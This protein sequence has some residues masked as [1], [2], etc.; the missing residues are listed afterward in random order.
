M[1]GLA[2]APSMATGK[3]MTK[4][5]HRMANTKTGKAAS[6]HIVQVSAKYRS[7]AIRSVLGCHGELVALIETSVAQ[8]ARGFGGLSGKSKRVDAAVETDEVTSSSR[9]GPE[10]PCC[11]VGWRVSWRVSWRASPPDEE[12]RA[13][14][15]PPPRRPCSAIS[16]QPRRTCSLRP[17]CCHCGD[18][19]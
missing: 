12:R 15:Q 6:N 2:S 13:E 18:R 19:V 5:F 3:M 8:P 14:G 16:L 17:A 7:S 11:T 4:A 9:R 10:C 1:S